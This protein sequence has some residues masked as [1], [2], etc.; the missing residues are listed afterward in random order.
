[1]R[2]RWVLQ[3]QSLIR[4]QLARQPRSNSRFVCL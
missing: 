1:V 3:H 4:N 2:K